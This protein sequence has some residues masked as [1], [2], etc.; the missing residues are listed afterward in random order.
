MTSD[1]IF[2]VLH[3][4]WAEKQRPAAH[5]LY[6]SSYMLQTMGQL[7]C[8]SRSRCCRSCW[9]PCWLRSYHTSHK[10]QCEVKAKQHVVTL[11]SK[12][13]Q[14]D[15]HSRSASH[16]ALTWLLVLSVSLS[17][18][19]SQHMIHS[20]LATNKSLLCLQPFL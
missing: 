17:F 10:A 20:T 16:G 4:C 9:R 1:N 5:D 3:T 18:C 12:D 15:V 19:H 8:L 13:H 14:T 6:P 2:T 11:R 7:R